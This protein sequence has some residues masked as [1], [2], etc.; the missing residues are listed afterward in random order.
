MTNGWDVATLERMSGGPP[1]MIR[2]Y[3]GANQV[4]LLMV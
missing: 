3:G 4:L 2:H 1:R